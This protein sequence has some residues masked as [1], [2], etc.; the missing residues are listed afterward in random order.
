MAEPLRVA[1]IVLAAGASTR[2]GTNK[3]LLRV[4]GQALVTR[5][6]TR[7]QVAGLTPLV[8]VIGHESDR[9]STELQSLSCLFAINPAF[10]GP[11]SGSL[12]AGLEQVPASSDAIVVILA[13]MVHTTAAMLRG[14]VDAARES[15]APLVVSRY[16]DVTAPPLLFRRSLFPELMAYNG[17]GCAKPVVRDH[18]HEAH[19]IDWPESALADVDTPEDFASLG[20]TT[21]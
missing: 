17:E 2:M 3:M 14:L 16:G 13:D 11:M 7:S 15:D 6:V 12:H 18:L 21:A 20:A 1:G 9:V 10:T 8:V 5:V 4:D 19:I